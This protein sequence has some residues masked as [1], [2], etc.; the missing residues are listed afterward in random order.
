V[1]S[2]GPAALS[3]P[4][5]ANLAWLREALGPRLLGELPPLADPAS[6]DG[7][8]LLDALAARGIPFAPRSDSLRRA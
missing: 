1:V 4:D 7:S 5:A 3:A 6:A 8:A 2:H